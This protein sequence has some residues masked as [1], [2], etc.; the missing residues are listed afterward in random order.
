MVDAPERRDIRDFSRLRI[1]GDVI[2]YV[3]HGQDGTRVPMTAPNTIG[4]R[5]FVSWV[6][7]HDSY[8]HR[9]ASK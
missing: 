6:Q 3:I 4:N 7:I 5:L 2:H 8:I 9:E 1:E